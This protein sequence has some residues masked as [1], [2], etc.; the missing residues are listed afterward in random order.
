MNDPSLPR[1]S[2]PQA[3]EFVMACH[4]IFSRDM[5]VFAH[6]LLFR[7]CADDD[8]AGIRDFAAATNQVIADGFSLASSRLGVRGRLTVNVGADNILSGNVRALPPG[9]V[10]L[11]V[12]GDVSTSELLLAACRELK[13]AGY[14]FLVDNYRPDAGGVA[15]LLQL[16]DY[17]KIPVD[18]ADG[19][20]VARLRKSVGGWQGKLIASKVE[21]WEAFEGCKFLG[22][23]YFQG[24][25]FSYPANMVGRKIPSHKTA[26]L[27][28]LRLLADDDIELSRLVEVIGTD[29]A[30]GIRLL[31]FANSAA[32]SL[33]D[34]VDSL[35]RAAALVG[36]NTLRKWAMA[37][38]LSDVDPSGKGQ[39]LSYRTLHCAMFL[40]RLADAGPAGG[41]DRET[42]YL[43][44]LL[45]KI[46]AL[47]G[48]PMKDIV[49][50][51]PLTASV[52]KALARDP[53]ESLAT[54]LQLADAIWKNEW[55]E[56]R[57]L[58]RELAIPLSKAAQSYM[59]AGEDTG[60]LL[61]SLSNAA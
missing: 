60:E 23:D 13:A 10:L 32:F 17:L 47:L 2:S 50:S 7:H 8:S 22:F 55:D 20:T 3:V 28:L 27:N 1:E 56:A 18:A 40:S 52:R 39:E 19:Q 21:S 14:A 31:Q 36:L 12:P 59:L 45:N 49:S 54:Y 38:A 41:P 26:R 33:G 5:D 6:E 15:E 11:E 34:R 44:G 30:L 58:L 24:F 61:R 37:V 9:R 53:K 4:P 16:A 42:L 25:F 57:P 43:L 48:M 51:M 29:P 35:G 46:D